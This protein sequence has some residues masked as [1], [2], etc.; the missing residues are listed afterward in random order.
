MVACPQ[1]GNGSAVQI[2]QDAAHPWEV[3][4]GGRRARWALR[5]DAC[6]AGWSMVD[7]AAQA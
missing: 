5:C 3:E 1:C 2:A 4:P 7:A 6:G